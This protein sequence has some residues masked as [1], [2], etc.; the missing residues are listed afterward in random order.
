MEVRANDLLPC[1]KI[2]RF[3]WGSGN[4]RKKNIALPEKLW[5]MNTYAGKDFLSFV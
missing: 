1:A 2:K 3:E 5:A 4:A